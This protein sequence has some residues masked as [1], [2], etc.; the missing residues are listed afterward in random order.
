MNIDEFDPNNPEA[1]G[2]GSQSYIP[3]QVGSLLPNTSMSRRVGRVTD[4]LVIRLSDRFQ[5]DLANFNHAMSKDPVMLQAFLQNPTGILSKS[6][7]P[8]KLLES[9]Q[10]IS[11]ANRFL[12][13]VFSNDAFRDWMRDYQSKITSNTIVVS[14]ESIQKDVAR[15]F[16]DYGDPA[17]M[18]SF[19]RISEKKTKS[20]LNKEFFNVVGPN[21]PT[22]E[23]GGGGGDED[24]DLSLMTVNIVLLVVLVIITFVVNMGAIVASERNM[25]TLEVLNLG[26][27]LIAEAKRL[28]STGEL[29]KPN[30][31]FGTQVNQIEI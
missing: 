21:E 19:L 13:S 15:A 12:F 1:T 31:T 8:K 23:G 16:L 14:K 4:P 17:V 20:E 5:N 2:S 6:L 18:Y 7:V 27:Q 10:R 28:A 26:D 24:D 22:M 30:R 3:L 25:S 9:P 11:E 29:L